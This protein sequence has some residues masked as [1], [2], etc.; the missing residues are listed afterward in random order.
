ML[1]KIG[2]K[3]QKGQKSSE[4]QN[5]NQKSCN[6]MGTQ[7]RLDECQTFVTLGHN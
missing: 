6:Y 5:R 2:I 1:F 7:K 4:V 3:L